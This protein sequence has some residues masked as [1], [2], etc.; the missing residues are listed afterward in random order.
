MKEPASIFHRLFSNHKFYRRHKCLS[1]LISL[2][3]T[4]MQEQIHYA[5]LKGKTLFFVLKHPGYVMEFNYNKKVINQVLSKLK[6]GYPFCEDVEVRAIQVYDKFIPQKDTIC[7]T[8]KTYTERA[9]GEFEIKTDD[10]E[11]K[12]LFIKIK[13]A[14]Q[15]QAGEEDKDS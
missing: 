6:R 12:E 4:T 5:Y 3:P 9:K 7:D 2:L 14:I 8:E 1:R 15:E 10:P 13:K 11:L